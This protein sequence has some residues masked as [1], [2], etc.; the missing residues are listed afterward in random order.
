MFG[1]K[2]VVNDEAISF[3]EEVDK[4]VIVGEEIL[5]FNEVGAFVFKIISQ[6]DGVDL[7]FI[8][9]AIENEFDVDGV[10]YKRAVKNFINKALDLDCIRLLE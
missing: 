3:L 7:N 5:K 2:I 10:D 8:F 9:R 6:Q 4:Y 1:K